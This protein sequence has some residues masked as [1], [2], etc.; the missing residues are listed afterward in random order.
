[1]GGKGMKICAVCGAEFDDS[2]VFCGNC[3]SKLSADVA[4]ASE[5]P[6]S[7]EAEP[8]NEPAPDLIPV[9]ELD[10]TSSEE[11]KNSEDIE[12]YEENQEESESEAPVL[13]FVEDYVSEEPESLEPTFG[14]Y[15]P[16]KYRSGKWWKILLAVLAGIVAVIMMFV[17]MVTVYVPMFTAS[18]YSKGEVRNGVYVNEFADLY[19]EMDTRWKNAPD[20]SYNACESANGENC[21]CGLYA[22][23]DNTELVVMFISG[24]D[25]TDAEDILE[26]S[27]EQYK[28]EN[29]LE[30]ALCD[31]VLR[32]H[33]VLD[34][35]ATVRV[36]VVSVGKIEDTEIADSDYA[37]FTVEYDIV[38]KNKV[39]KSEQ[40]Y[41]TYR[42]L[43]VRVID[44]YAI[45]IQATSDSERGVESALKSF[46]TIPF[47][48]YYEAEYFYESFPEDQ[49][50]F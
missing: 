27:A 8:V 36:D 26:N 30:D 24:A 48:Y 15:R 22:T 33:G 47:E 9:S 39:F 19:F 42:T 20:S 21:E 13:G 46:K 40:T 7:E 6:I 32:D 45:V 14:V 3:G 34:G 10:M 2:A 1:M 41:K 18:E 50:E 29:A 4:V 31:D 44:D 49:N 37:S 35:T 28:D 25:G 38:I 16:K 11:E 5:E 12:E 17:T 23:R 43:C